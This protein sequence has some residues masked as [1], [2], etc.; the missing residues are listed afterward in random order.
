MEWKVKK[1][2]KEKIAK[3]NI[4]GFSVGDVINYLKE[5]GIEIVQLDFQ[6]C[7]KR[8]A[9]KYAIS[10]G[11]ISRYLSGIGIGAVAALTGISLESIEEG[12]RAR[13]AGREKLIEHNLYLINLVI[14]E[15]RSN[16]GTPFKLKGPVTDSREFLVVTGNDIIAM[17][18]IVGGLRVQTYYPITPAADEN[19]YLEEKMLLRIGNKS[20]G[21]IVVMQTEDE[22]AAIASA[23]GAALAG[24]RA[25]TSTSG[26]GFSLMVEG[27]GWAGMN[28]VPVVI[29]YYQRGG[30]STGMPT[31]GVQSDLF[32]TL[33]AGHGEFARIVLASGDHL[34]AF[35]DAV[36]A[37][38]L[39][40]KHQVPVIHLVDKFL[41]NSTATIPLP[42]LSRVRIERGNIIEDNKEYYKRFDLERI[43]SPRAFL[44]S[45]AIM[46]YTGSEHDEYGHVS[47]D[48][49]N[50]LEMYEKRIK[51]MDLIDQELSEEKRVILYGSKKPQL[52]LI[53]WG[54]TKGPILD[55]LPRLESLGEVA[56]LHFRVLVP[57]PKRIV[58]EV[59]SGAEKVIGVEHSYFVQ[60]ADLVS[61]HTSI[62]VP[63]RIAKWTGRPI[64]ENEIVDAV[65]KIV[66]ENKKRVVLTYGE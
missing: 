48:P 62:P 9:Q 66:E 4:R 51:K 18:K 63:Y 28:E 33:Y 52:V 53:G 60:I 46:W 21:G 43:V 59:I 56:Y 17:G 37:F 12:L 49:V 45:N 44:G 14:E 1:R 26:P 19:L 29:T 39:A 32:F 36:E 54:S 64:Y 55:A 27:L 42:D 7:L 57:F 3:Q 41:A 20:L 65:K 11:A 61:L 23:I 38:N 47:E 24:A 50:R 13:L 5:K 40:E 6:K 34:E 10:P 30:P 16:H 2:L 15:I 58:R 22:I 8:L 35:Y 31:R 25:A